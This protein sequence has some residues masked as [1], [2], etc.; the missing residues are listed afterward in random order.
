MNVDQI[1]NELIEILKVLK[2]S[3]INKSIALHE[4]EFSE[5]EKEILLD[6]IETTYVSQM[7]NIFKI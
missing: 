3:K 4:P 5:K 6:C 7:V 2:I 1:S